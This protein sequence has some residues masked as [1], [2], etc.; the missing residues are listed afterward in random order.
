MQRQCLTF[1]LTFHIHPVTGRFSVMKISRGFATF[2]N[3]SVEAAQVVRYKLFKE[4]EQREDKRNY[5]LGNDR[6]RVT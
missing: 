2:R 6:E 4:T 5:I 3:G 1:W